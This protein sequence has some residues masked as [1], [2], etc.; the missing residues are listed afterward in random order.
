MLRP[1][2]QRHRPSS[3]GGGDADDGGGGLVPRADVETHLR[4]RRKR[5]ISPQI[6]MAPHLS[7]RILVLVNKLSG[8]AVVMYMSRSFTLMRR[9]MSG[10][11]V[12]LCHIAASG[13]VTERQR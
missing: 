5:S 9:A 6:E 13:R 4:K 3:D 11:L 1:R 12:S 2:T 10:G 7:A 8:E